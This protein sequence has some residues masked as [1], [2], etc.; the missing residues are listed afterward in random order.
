MN[1]E[2]AGAFVMYGSRSAMELGLAHI[3]EQIKAIEGAVIEKP[4]LAIDLSKTLVESAC[5]TVLRERGIEYDREDNLPRLFR[6]VCDA[7]P[8]LPVDA[9]SEVGARRSIL[10]AIGGMSAAVQG[11]CELRNSYGLASHGA[12]APRAALGPTQ[13]MLS[14]QAADSIVG[15]LYRVHREGQAQRVPLSFEDNVTFNDYVDDVHELIEIFGLAYRP[16]EVL[17]RIDKQAYGD[18]LASFADGEGDP[19]SALTPSKTEIAASC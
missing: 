19:E 17:F 2:T 12:D 3:E 9:A 8:I 4:S 1:A 7:L 15:F 5:R 16:S 14:A 13:A 18:Q 6:T 10:K 11:I